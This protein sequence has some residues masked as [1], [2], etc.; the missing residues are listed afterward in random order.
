MDFYTLIT[1]PMEHRFSMK[2]E[3][4]LS[5]FSPSFLKLIWEK[6][7]VFSL[8]SYLGITLKL[9]KLPLSFPSS[10]LEISLKHHKFPW[11][12]CHVFGQISPNSVLIEM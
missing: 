3:F 8:L 5:S 7:T 1:N 12:R 4:S 10:L 9:K 6:F 11:H 2:L